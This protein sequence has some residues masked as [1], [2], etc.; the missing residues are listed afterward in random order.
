MAVDR[1]HLGIRDTPLLSGSTTTASKRCEFA[2]HP[3]GSLA[4]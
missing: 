3:P 2:K 4:H 1:N